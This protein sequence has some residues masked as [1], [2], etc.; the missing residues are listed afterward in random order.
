MTQISRNGNHRRD[1][2]I[3]EVSSSSFRAVPDDALDLK[4]A[5]AE[6][7]QQSPPETRDAEIVDHLRMIDWSK[8]RERFEFHNDFAVA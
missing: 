2:L 6:V 3:T 4:A 8:R 7:E 1:R 5:C